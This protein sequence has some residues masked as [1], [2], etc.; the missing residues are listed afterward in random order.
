[1][2]QDVRRTNSVRVLIAAPDASFESSLRE[3]LLARDFT[4]CAT[5]RDAH[6]A[7]AIALSEQPDVCVLVAELPGSAVVATA[8]ITHRL[9]RTPVV[10]LGPTGDEEDCVTYFM[11]GASGYLDRDIPPDALGI[12]IRTAAAGQPLV[13][14]TV[15]RRLLDE[16]RS[17]LP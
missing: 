1:M 13:S 15:Q 5:A 11:A 7:V 17:D 9:P 10:I 6:G 12:A 16:L 8:E 3:Q 4:L 14:A 2:A